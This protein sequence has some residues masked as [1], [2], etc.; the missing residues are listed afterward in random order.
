M[1]PSPEHGSLRGDGVVLASVL[2]LAL[3]CRALAALAL[4]VVF[5]EVC[6]MAYGLSRAFRGVRAFLFEAPIAVSNGITPL[7]LWVQAA[8][9]ALLGETTKA[10]LR[11]LPVALGL[12]AVWL[13]YREAEALGGRA[14]ALLGGFLAAVHGPYLFANAR[15]EYSE[16][17]LVVLG[18]LVLRDLRRSGSSLPGFRA[19]AWP[20]LALLAYLG[21]GLVLWAAYSAC[22]AL[23]LAARAWAG[24]MSPRDAVRGAALV[25]LPLL[26]SLAWLA[27]AQVL[28]FRAG[29]PV[30]TDLGPV[31]S[32][33]TNLRRLTLGY[34]TEAQPF[35]VGSARDALWVYTD[36][37]VW[38]TLGLLAVPAVVVLVLRG[39]DLVRA[40]S[41]GDG[42]AAAGALCP[43]ALVLV[44][45]GLLV[46]KGALDVRFHLLYWPVLLVYCAVGI[47][48]WPALL[49]NGR[50]AAFW[51]VGLLV[52]SYVAWTCTAPT[53]L[54]WG[55]VGAAVAILALVASFKAARATRLV[56]LPLAVF[57]LWATL[58]LG[59]LDWGRRWAWEPSPL[60]SDVPRAVATFPNVDLQL[61]RCSLGRDT[62]AEAR[63][64]L[65]RALE[66]HP[67][68]RQTVLEV[69]ESL[70]SGDAGD[71]RLA[72]ASLG[73]LS[74][75]S[76]EDPEVQ[77]LLETA[78]RAAARP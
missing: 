53:R 34:G 10:G 31:D 8:P 56:F 46:V 44:P 62:L 24:T 68:D 60:A 12:A 28:L 41:G 40:L 27:A 76:P 70:L 38:P 2:G 77:R 22:V 47:A 39:R 7:W 52:W 65:S 45:A 67:G 63:P 18:L 25:A 26:P 15:G 3:A 29:H 6:V 43:L 78:V 5:D 74:R 50:R 57:A 23:L 19:A 58:S 21:K 1:G 55:L 66:R 73:E 42:E 35:M 51:S 17:L 4:P 33:W 11:T 13:T 75:R 16:S 64:F 49:G 61:V 59:P 30:V 32:V 69:G 72:L 54:V 48:A 36:F 37:D 71:V 9:A 14:A 20:A